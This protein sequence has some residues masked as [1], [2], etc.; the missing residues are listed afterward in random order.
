MPCHPED[1][2]VNKAMKRTNKRNMQ[3]KLVS[4]SLDDEELNE[5]KEV[6]D[7]EADDESRTKPKRK[8]KGYTVFE[9]IKKWITG[10]RATVEQEDIDREIFELARDFM[11]ASGLQ[12]VPGHVSKE[13]DIGLWK[14]A[15]T[16]SRSGGWTLRVFKCPMAFRC[17]CEAQIRITEGFCHGDGFTLLEKSGTHDINSHQKDKSKFLKIKHIE[18]VHNAVSVAPTVAATALRRNLA[19]AGEEVRIDP[20]YARCIQRQV[21]KSRKLLTV[22]QLLGYEI[23]SSFGALTEFASNF[24]INSLNDRHNDDADPFHFD[25]FRPFVIGKDIKAERDIVHIK[26]SSPWFICNILRQIAAG[27]IFQ[28]NADGTFG[29]CRHSVEMIDFGVNSVGGHNHRARSRSHPLTMS[30]AGRVDSSASP[31]T[32]DKSAA[33]AVGPGA[34]TSLPHTSRARSCSLTLTLSPAG[35]PG[36]AS[37]ASA[38]TPDKSAATAAGKARAPPYPISTRARSRSRALTL[39]PAGRVA[40]AAFAVIAG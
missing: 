32:A 7:D 33:T 9:V 11:S 8:Y 16:H 4:E 1:K 28:I 22:A 17:D 3:A 12:K 19:L 39:C 15:R 29:F 5:E 36:V 6:E 18:A 13:T 27:W 35:R 40:F 20:K 31:F 23:G 38:V 21:R 10:E 37:T 26:F 34:S 30:P 14:L 25:L 2:A 24:W